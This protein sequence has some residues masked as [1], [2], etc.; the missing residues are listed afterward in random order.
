VSYDNENKNWRVL[1]NKEIYAIVKKPTKTE[2]IKL[3]RLCWFGNGQRMEEHRIP[4]E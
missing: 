2:I 3:H 1:T 4:I